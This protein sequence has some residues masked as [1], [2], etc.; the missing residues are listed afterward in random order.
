MCF[1]ATKL[2]TTFLGPFHEEAIIHEGVI[3]IRFPLQNFQLG[4]NIKDK[5]F[6]TVG[7]D[8]LISDEN[9]CTHSSGRPILWR[10]TLPLSF[11]IQRQEDQNLIVSRD[12]LRLIKAHSTIKKIDWRTEEIAILLQGRLKSF[13]VGE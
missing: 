10:A 3:S 8:T 2:M 13:R 9:K 12:G 4:C 5:G 7:L 6:E 1:N 11:L